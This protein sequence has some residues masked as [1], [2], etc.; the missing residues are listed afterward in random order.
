M[1]R[2]LQ[3]TLLVFG[4]L[5]SFAFAAKPV[6]LSEELPHLHCSWTTDFFPMLTL[7]NPVNTS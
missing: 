6:N 5:P 4:V 1:N 2:L 3:L 7:S